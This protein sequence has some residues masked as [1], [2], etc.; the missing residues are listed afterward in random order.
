MGRIKQLLANDIK[1]K[2]AGI[3]LDGVLR[4]KVM[5]KDKFLSS[6]STGFGMSSVLFGWDMHDVTYS[7]E[8][9]L[10]ASGTSYEDLTALIDVDSFRRL[11]FEE[12]IAFFLLHF[13]VGRKPVAV[14]GRS[15]MQ[16]LTATMASKGLKGLAGGKKENAPWQRIS[17]PSRQWR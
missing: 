6:L 11:P 7:E 9:E 17:P 12:N 8:T 15:Q 5:H 10:L 3:D 16:S 14:D 4:S 13:H 2:V 1:I